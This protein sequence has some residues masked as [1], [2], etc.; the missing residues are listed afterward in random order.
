MAQ[1]I[2]GALD[3]KSCYPGNFQRNDSGRMVYVGD[4]EDAEI[5]QDDDDIDDNPDLTVTE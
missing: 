2:C 5:D 4:S 3:C 1:C